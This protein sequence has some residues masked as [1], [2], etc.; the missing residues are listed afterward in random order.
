[1]AWELL[2]K[3]YELSPNKLFVTYF[4]GCE[5]LGLLPDLETKEIWSQIGI[6]LITLHYHYH[7]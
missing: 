2:T 1:M 5:E 4:G 3:H 7:S 6:S